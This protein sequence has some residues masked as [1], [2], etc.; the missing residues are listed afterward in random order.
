MK[1]MSR[2]LEATDPAV[3]AQARRIS[4][5]MLFRLAMLAAFTV[6]VGILFT[7]EHLPT[8]TTSED[9]SHFD[10]VH[11]WL[12]LGTLVGGYVLT[13]VYA[14][15]LPR[16]THLSRFAGVQTAFDIALSAIVVHATGGVESGFVSLYLIAVLGAATM[17]GR[18]HTWTAAGACAAVY[19]VMSTLEFTDILLPFT[20]QTYA[21]P[22]TAELWNTVGR[23]VAGLV[24]VTVL[25][26]YLNTQLATSVSLVGSLRALNE[27][28]VR[29]LN[30]GLVTVDQEGR[31]LYFNPAARQ[32]LDLD[33]DLIGRNIETVFPGL[34]DA[35][36]TTRDGSGR[37]EL[38]LKT[39]AGRSL[40]VGL[41]RA[42]LWDGD[43]RRVG[44][45]I[46]FQDVTRLHELAQTVRRNERLAALGGMAASVAHEIRN[47]LAAIGGSAEL[48]GSA[49]LGDEDQRLLAVIRREST[50]LGELVDDLLAFTR[51]R[52]PEPV[53]VNLE[54]ACRQAAEAFMADPANA[55]IVVSFERASDAA[56]DDL[57]VSV[58]PAQLS[59]VLWNL[60][61]NA[62]EAMN[63]SGLVRMRLRAD[64]GSVGVDVVD[65][66]PGVAPE[67][68]ESI[69]DPFFTTKTTGTGFGLAI[70][71]RIVE[72][73]GGRVAVTSKPAA[74]ATFSV[75]FPR[76]GHPDEMADPRD[77][78]VLEI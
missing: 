46:N 23:T 48:L 39:P 15:W 14:R 12:I 40:H 43:G 76:A 29:S 60:M 53:L 32:I 66:G 11:A 64:D 10:G 58:D 72:D 38:G 56:A 62:A 9:P 26:S 21:R 7:T 67:H 50:R 35:D 42:P 73:N 33:D 17:G 47:P 77:S 78:G 1:T 69:F 18:R 36:S 2:S 54:T 19:L 24:G 51:P 31:L 68:L 22:S 59:Q 8:R 70:V 4:Y 71:H 16:T 37:L 65:E 63:G 30:S 6:L 5:F 52:P 44:S 27:N 55:S 41:N 74:G 45:V 13:I 34:V 20:D 61:R 49:E 3:R 57:A 28:I 25:S 75:S